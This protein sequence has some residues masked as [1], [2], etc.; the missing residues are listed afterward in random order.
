MRDLAQKFRRVPLFLKRI[1]FVGATDNF[2]ISRNELPFLSFAL[3]RH[4]RALHNNRSTSVEPLDVRVIWQRILLRDDL[5][6]AQRR[7]IIQLDKR[8]VFRISSRA[9]PPLHTNRLN[10]R[11]ALQCVFNRSWR[12]FRHGKFNRLTRSSPDSLAAILAAQP[13]MSLSPL[14]PF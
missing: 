4:Q 1:T 11:S 3:R 12:N 13:S 6:I 14:A 10:R 9:G 8:K 2:D 5:K 7:A